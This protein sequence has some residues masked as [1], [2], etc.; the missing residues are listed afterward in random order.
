MPHWMWPMGPFSP[1]GAFRS[2]HGHPYEGP[3]YAALFW[4]HNFRTAPFEYLGA[5]GLVRRGM[6][7]LRVNSRRLDQD[8]WRIGASL[9]R[10]DFDQ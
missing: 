6:G 3:R 10:S 4:E 7:L 2:V 8:G 5:W 9:A 1:F